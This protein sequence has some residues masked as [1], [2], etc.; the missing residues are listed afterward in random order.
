MPFLIYNQA[1]LSIILDIF[2]YRW[3]RS[4]FPSPIPIPSTF[5]KHRYRYRYQIYFD[6]RYRVADTAEI[7]DTIGTDT[8]TE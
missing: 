6:Y 5:Q 3:Y 7:A 8:D 1:I 4:N 2:R